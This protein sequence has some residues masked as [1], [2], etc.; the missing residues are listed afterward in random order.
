MA[1]SKITNPY[2][3]ESQLVLEKI[4]KYRQDLARAED[5]L[6]QG[7]FGAV[8][9]LLDADFKHFCDIVRSEALTPPPNPNIHAQRV[10]ARWEQ[11][12]KARQKYGTR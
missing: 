10:K 5:L 1:D 12:R 6:R 4:R 9:E 8:N 7:K 3:V 11:M 2:S